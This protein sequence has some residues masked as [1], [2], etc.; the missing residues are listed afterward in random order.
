MLGCFSLCST[1]C[2]P[3]DGSPS[4][5]SVGSGLPCPPPGDIPHL[6][7]EPVSAE[8]PI[9][10]ILYCLATREAHSSISYTPIQNKMFK[11]WKKINVHLKITIHFSTSWWV[12]MSPIILFLFVFYTD[13]VSCSRVGTWRI[14][15][16]TR[17]TDCEV[18]AA[19]RIQVQTARL[20][21][22]RDK[23]RWPLGQNCLSPIWRRSNKAR[24]SWGWDFSVPGRVQFLADWYLWE[25]LEKMLLLNLRKECG[26]TGILIH[27]G[28]EPIVAQLLL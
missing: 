20:S 6:G 10:Q 13:Q 21:W 28:W 11:A 18:M 3:M 2:D 17:S 24:K 1:L 7:I 4:G 26:A 12:Q 5:S 9:L 8:A 23:E 25:G 27:C 14:L 15:E 16:R 19:S 22:G